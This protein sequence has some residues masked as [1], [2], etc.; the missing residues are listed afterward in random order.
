MEIAL[1]E[2]TDLRKLIYVFYLYLVDPLHECN[3]L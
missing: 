2:L 3:A 1:M